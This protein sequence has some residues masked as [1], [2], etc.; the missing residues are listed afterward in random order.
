MVARLSSP[1]LRTLVFDL[2][3]EM[4]TY[5]S[6]ELPDGA[7]AYDNQIDALFRLDKSASDTFDDLIGSGLVVKPNDQTDARWFADAVSGSS[8]YYHSSYLAST[9]TVTMTASQW[10]YLGNVAATFATSMGNGSV[11]SINNTTGEVTYNG[12][13]R[14][15][16]VNVTV[17]VLNGIGATPVIVQAC[18][19]RSN[20]VVAGTTTDYSIK[21]EQESDMVNLPVQMTLQRIMI[22][23]PGTTLRLAFRNVT[24]G[25]DLQVVFYQLA[26]VPI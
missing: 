14:L 12:P 22:L 21:G 23:N 18:I 20:D 24:N 7:T 17:S 2:S 1:A 9:A 5:N 16:L 19:S 3:S 6:S 10:G 26:V 11:W 15:A 4:A 13:P 25:D 8:P